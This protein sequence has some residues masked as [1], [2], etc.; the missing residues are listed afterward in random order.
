MAMPVMGNI[1]VDLIKST[2]LAFM[3]SVIEITGEAKILG[4]EVLRYF[5]AYL[6]VFIVY[7]VL[8]SVVER[9][10]RLLEKRVSVY[11]RGTH[12]AAA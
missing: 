1:V 3:M 11:R 6:C 4:G 12:S 7:I 2:S 10:L 5:E 9:L 8:I